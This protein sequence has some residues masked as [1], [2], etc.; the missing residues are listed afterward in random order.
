MSPRRAVLFGL[1]FLA[2]G[3]VRVA[4]QVSMAP[5]GTVPHPKVRWA[6]STGN[7]VTFDITN[8]SST[9]DYS[10][11]RTC[12]GTGNVTIT[13]TCPIVGL[14]AAG[15]TKTVTVTFSVGAAG[16]GN[17]QLAVAEAPSTP[18]GGSASGAWIITTVNSAATVAPNGTTVQVAPNRTGLTQPFTISNTSRGAGTFSLASV[19]SGTGVSTCSVSP[20]TL[21]LDSAGVAGASG[22]ATITHNSAAPPNHTGSVGVSASFN[23]TS[24][25][26]ASV[27]VHV[28][29]AQVTPDG[30]AF[31]TTTSQTGVTVNFNVNNQGPSTA[32]L[33]LSLPTCTGVSTCRFSSGATTTTVPVGAGATS[34]VPV[35]FNTGASATTGTVALRASFNS[36]TLDDGT[37]NVTVTAPPMA[38]VTAT[39]SLPNVVAPGAA[40]TQTFSVRNDGT[41]AA[42][43]FS[44]DCATMS[45]AAATGCSVTSPT[46]PTTIN[47]GATTTVTVSFTGSTT[48]GIQ[49]TLTL[50]ALVSSVLAGS[51]GAVIAIPNATATN[52]GAV[53]LNTGAAGSASYS[54]TNTGTTSVAFSLTSLCGGQATGCGN[55]SPSSVTLAA[56]ATT[57]S[58]V[59]VGYAASGTPGSGTVTLQVRYPNE[60]GAI[61]GTGVQNVTV[62]SGPVA[63][64]VDV[65]AAAVDSVLVRSQCVAVAVG[66]GAATECGDLRL[67]HPLP[68]VRTMSA[69]RTPMLVYN[70][71]HANTW[72]NLPTDLTLPV[73]GPIPTTV[74]AVLKINNVQVGATH[75][76]TGSQWSAG[77]TRRVTLGF[78][79]AS[80]AGLGQ[81]IYPYVLE[82]TNTFA[83]GATVVATRTGKLVVVDRRLTPFGAGWWLAGLETLTLTGAPQVLTWYGG[84]GSAMEYR[85]R[86][87]TT[88]PNRIWDG[89]VLTHPNEIRETVNAGQTEYVRRLPDSVRVD[90]NATGQHVRTRNRLGHV[91]AFGYTSGRLT[92][93]TLPTNTAAALVY[94]L[95]YDASN[96]L[97]AVLAPGASGTRTVNIAS[98]GSR[99]VTSITDPG[100]TRVIGFGYTGG[101]LRVSSRTDA[102]T[103]VT[104]FTY[105]GVNKIA[106]AVMPLS[107]VRTISSLPLTGANGSGGLQDPAAVRYY[108]SGPG[109]NSIAFYVN[110]YGAPDRIVNALGQQTTLTRAQTGYPGLVTGMI[111][112]S[113]QQIAASYDGQGRLASV[114][115][116]SWQNSTTSYS[117]GAFDQVSQINAPGGVTTTITLD[118]ATGNRVSQVDNRGAGSQITFG[119]DPTTKLL[120]SV[121]GP[122]A[123]GETFR[124]DPEGQRRSRHH[125]HRLR[126][127][128][129]QQRDRAPHPGVEPDRRGADPATDDQLQLRRLQPGHGID[130]E[131]PGS[132]RHHDPRVRCRAQQDD[133]HDA[134][135]ADRLGL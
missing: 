132:D 83:G 53:T 59:T 3:A 94:T 70:S 55:P 27:T 118:A 67:I 89:P 29:G 121:G 19:C 78:N 60:T 76:W 15:T 116:N 66:P 50:Q 69:S 41:T 134:A 46:Q 113:G 1:V 109:T 65:N 103:A 36:V 28:I 25:G 22:S 68:T 6:S 74:T 7:T 108:V 11:T 110:R 85:L 125:R 126:H 31:S 32:T 79:A 13:G 93:I 9:N 106:T 96:V 26:S 75:S 4:G 104:S 45:P 64:V 73:N 77:S 54:V 107:I 120:T 2:G 5:V 82:V 8:L 72:I 100:G 17:V 81:G 123:Y 119:Y 44:H 58:P 12:T 97:N 92:S 14:V 101:D 112:T 20:A 34:V 87:G 49:G 127:Q 24:Y 23:G 130:L 90:F 105:D 52:P 61:L 47:G 21:T 84:D 35:L 57:V 91:T 117:Y 16:T 71:A 86:A 111:T 98:D 38:T 124:I 102:R 51:G 129:H 18:G 30:Q 128:R 37:F 42:F 40:A 62:Q 33:S 63:M 115:D 99:R 135:R 80:G 122:G 131:R 95:T 39:G 48:K 56:G 43:T 10:Y 114:I 133:H 88:A